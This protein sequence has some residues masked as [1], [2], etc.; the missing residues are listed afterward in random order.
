LNGEFKEINSH[1]V[2]TGEDQT[3]TAMSNTVGLP[4]AICAKMILNGTI[5]SKGVHLPVR[6]E[7]YQPILKE[8]EDYNIKFIDNVIEP[9][10]LYL[11]PSRV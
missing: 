5:Q 11:E 7:I 2:S 10:V 9:P 4:C 1:M 3:Y 8:L 6:K